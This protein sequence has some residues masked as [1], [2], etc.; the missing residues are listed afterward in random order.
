MKLV[1]A[2]VTCLL[3]LPAVASAEV[4]HPPSGAVYVADPAAPAPRARGSRDR[5][6]PL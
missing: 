4:I 3:A 6:A 2:I 1:A 5:P